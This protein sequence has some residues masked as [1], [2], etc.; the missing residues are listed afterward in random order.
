M[1]CI[2]QLSDPKCDEHAEHDD[3]DFA[4]EGAPAMQRL[5]KVN[6]RATGPHQLRER[7]R[8]PYVRNG[9]KADILLFIVERITGVGHAPGD[10]QD[11][12]GPSRQ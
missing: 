11:E 5:W 9:W 7:N 4:S 8:R 6:L 10:V 2:D 1:P 3:A 12:G